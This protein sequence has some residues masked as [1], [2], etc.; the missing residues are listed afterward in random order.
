MRRSG[1]RKVVLGGLLLSLLGW[2]GST[3]IW[4]TPKPARGAAA[5]VA[6]AAVA[7]LPVERRVLSDEAA[8]ALRGLKESAWPRNPFARD[9]RGGANASGVDRSSQDEPE[10]VL[11]GTLMCGGQRLALIGEG[12]YGVGDKLPDGAVLVGI[13]AYGV[14]CEG[15]DGPRTLRLEE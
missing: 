6:P 8:A 11:R 15:P 12:L 9:A 1:W 4:P 3:Y 5:A 14:T 13:D 7:G 10:V 2:L